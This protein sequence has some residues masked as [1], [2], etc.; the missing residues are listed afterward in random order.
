MQYE[1]WWMIVFYLVCYITTLSVTKLRWHGN[2]W[3]HE[4]IWSVGGMKL[5][6]ESRSIRSKSCP[7]VTLSNKIPT[8]LAWNWTCSS[9][10]RGW[11]LTA[12]TA[13]RLRF[14]LIFTKICN[15]VYRRNDVDWMLLQIWE[16]VPPDTT[17]GGLSFLEKGFTPQRQLVDLHWKCIW[18]EIWNLYLSSRIDSATETLSGKFALYLHSLSLSLSHTH[19]HTNT[20]T[21]TH[22][23][24]H[25]HTHTHTR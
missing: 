24:T 13:T 22:T 14:Y 12:W 10:P 23:Q 19:K 1:V 3:M 4:W 21:N 18:T 20:N 15:C 8:W 7:I 17:R 9:E 5:I 2:E 6:R 11:R 25:T 16:C